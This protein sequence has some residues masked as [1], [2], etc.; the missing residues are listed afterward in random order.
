MALGSL[1]FNHTTNTAEQRLIEDLVTESIKI[2]GIEVGYLGK[3]IVAKDELYTEDEEAKFEEV[4]DVVMY[5]KSADGF[6]GEGDFLS[7]FGLEIRDQMTLCV[8]RRHFAESVEQEQNIFRPREGDLIFLPLNEKM[9]QINFVEHEP[10]FYQMGSLQFYELTC[11]LFEYSNERFNTKIDVIDQIQTTHSLDIYSEV[12]MTTENDLP[13]FTEDGY[14]LLSEDEDRLD[15]S[16]DT[17]RD[18]DTITDSESIYIET[19][20][21]SILDFSEADPFSEGNL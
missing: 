9:F 20:G 15:S 11:E 17:A 14:R 5:I 18:F 19:Q 3:T 1:Y 7:K 21:D 2:Y 16:A 8:A 13:I 4:T 12:E 6:Q 10:V